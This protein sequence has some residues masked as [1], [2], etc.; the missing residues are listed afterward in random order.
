MATMQSDANLPAP[1]E[2]MCLARHPFRG[3]VRCIFVIVGVLIF[4]AIVWCTWAVIAHRRL[5]AQIDAIAALHQPF[6]AE[7]FATSKLPDS[8]NAA[9]A[10][11]AVFAAVPSNDMAPANSNMEY[12]NYPPFPAAWHQMEDQSVVLNAQ[13]FALAKQAAKATEFE[14]GKISVHFNFGS[15]PFSKSRQTANVLADAAVDAHFKG[16]DVR[17]IELSTE[18]LH[19]ARVM[20]GAGPVIARLVGMGIQS[21]CLNRLLIITPDLLVQRDPQSTLAPPQ[22]AASREQLQLLMKMLLDEHGE[23]RGREAA[24]DYERLYADQMI[25]AQRTHLLLLRP[26][27]NL[28]EARVLNVRRI[29]RLA[30]ECSDAVLSA[31]LYRQHPA[32]MRGAVSSGFITGSVQKVPPSA[33]LIDDAFGGSLVRY[34][35]M[36]WRQ[37]A[38]RRMAAVA[39]AIRLYRVDHEQWPTTLSDLVPAYLDSVPADPF[40]PGNPPVGY[41]IR[42]HAL[43]D[44]GDRPMLYCGPVGDPQTAKL[45]ATPIFGS[46]SEMWRDLSR[47]YPVNTVK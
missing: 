4:T 41:V 26:M 14:W 43:P 36:E 12:P 42:R 20:A 40:M 25:D 24:I 21:L 18:V 3:V 1:A 19:E 27:A 5:S 6:R 45:S 9:V 2:N 35:Q 11:Q 39:L 13:A 32:P 23:Q 10:W 16:D 31:E 7:E 17:A 37:A 44:G 38:M 34:Q 33:R 15:L 29:D 47:W 46:G 30:A 22:K 28:S 8:E